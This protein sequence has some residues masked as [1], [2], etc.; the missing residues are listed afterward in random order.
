MEGEI[1]ELDVT[2]HVNFRDSDA[3]IF[4]EI[5]VGDFN[6]KVGG[7]ET[8]YREWDGFRNPIFA[9][10]R[11]INSILRKKPFNMTNK[12][13]SENIR[14][15]IK[16]FHHQIRNEDRMPPAY[17]EKVKQFHLAFEELKSLSTKIE[18]LDA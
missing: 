1:L 3:K 10:K 11:F 6:G 12:G 18:F 4:F 5:F 16:K 8:E 15:V 7:E 2:S 13:R 17:I 9:A 14:Y